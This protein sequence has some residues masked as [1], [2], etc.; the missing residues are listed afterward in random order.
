MSWMFAAVILMQG[1]GPDA[2]KDKVPSKN[3]PG[4]FGIAVDLKDVASGKDPR[5]LKA[6]LVHLARIGQA[7]GKLGTCIQGNIP[8]LHHAVLA[9][10]CAKNP[11]FDMKSYVKR[12]MDQMKSRIESMKARSTRR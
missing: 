5:N 7:M 1:A 4:H 8:G 12:L 2:G 9:A 3:L 11:K 10:G 6:M